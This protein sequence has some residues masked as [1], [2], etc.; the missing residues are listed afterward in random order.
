[1]RAGVSINVFLNRLTVEGF[2][3]LGFY[4][5]TGEKKS[6]FSASVDAGAEHAR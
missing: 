4:G 2:N 6:S 5:S 3:H 1:M